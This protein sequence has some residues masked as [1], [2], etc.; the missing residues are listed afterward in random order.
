MKSISELSLPISEPEYRVLGGF[1][2]S[3]LATFLREDDPKV[4]VESTKKESGALRFGSLVDCLMT[5]PEMIPERFCI[6]N[7]TSPSDQIISAMLYIY[8]TMPDAR[9][10]MYVPDDLK[11]EGAA[12]AEYG[13]TWLNTTV[14]KKLNDNASYYTYLQ[15]AEGK[16]LVSHTDFKTA[17]ECVHILKTHPFTEKYMGDGDPFEEGIE[18][19]NQ[20]KFKSAYDNTLIRCM[21]DRIIVNHKDKTIQPIDLKTTGKA[22]KKFE[23]SV[24]DWDYYIQAG[25][26]SQILLDVISQDDY[27]KDFTILPFKF[28]VINRYRRKPQ[29][30]TYKLVKEDNDLIDP[31]EEVLLQHG[32]KPWRRLVIEANWHLQTGKFDYPYETYVSGG[33]QEINIIRCLNVRK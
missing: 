30:W 24:L 26:Y 22:E 21:F 19:I 31:N 32:F 4:L 8:D 13:K 23:G 2:Y 6:R 14:L 16:T 28:V 10:F 9:T 11:L 7:F 18:R 25:M 27:F 20:L 3:L 15:E 1:S 5:E 29:V 17:E 12:H 33:D